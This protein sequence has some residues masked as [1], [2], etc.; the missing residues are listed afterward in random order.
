MLFA[1]SPAA[2][3]DGP[4]IPKATGGAQCV[5]D[6]AF[7][8]RHHMTMLRHQR[9][10]TV[11]EGDRS[12]DFSLAGCIACHAVPGADGKPVAY[13]DSRHFCRSCHDYEAVKVDCFDCHRSTPEIAPKAASLDRDYATLA[14][15]LQEPAR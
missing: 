14:H 8:R 6:A 7:M 4:V 2:A 5:R 1:A 11:H 9:D 15:F 13:S 10:A 12:G 3:E